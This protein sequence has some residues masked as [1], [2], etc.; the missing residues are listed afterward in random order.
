MS[1]T[2]VGAAIASILL[3]GVTYSSDTGLP[4]LPMPPSPTSGPSIPADSGGSD[5]EN[6]LGS[7]GLE[8]SAAD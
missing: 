3:Q 6:D 5:G 2:V 7:L 4:Y 8:S 1:Q